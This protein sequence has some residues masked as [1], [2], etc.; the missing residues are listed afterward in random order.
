MHKEEQTVPKKQS[1]I[2]GLHLELGKFLSC[3]VL[4]QFTSTMSIKK[5]KQCP[6]NKADWHTLISS[7]DYHL[8]TFWLLLAKLSCLTPIASQSKRFFDVF[9]K[10][11]EN[12]QKGGQKGYLEAFSDPWLAQ[13]SL[14]LTWAPKWLK[15]EVTSSPGWAANQPS[16]LISYK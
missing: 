4:P 7:G 3:S 14:W 13:A 9:E 1:H 12:T 8:L 16:P 5:S 10:N 15:G 11:M 2:I 6:E